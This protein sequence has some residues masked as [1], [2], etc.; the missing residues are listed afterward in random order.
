MTFVFFVLLK[1]VFLWRDI[2]LLQLLDNLLLNK[3]LVVLYFL[4]SRLA[5]NIF[6]FCLTGFYY[7][8][9]VVYFHLN[10]LFY[11]LLLLFNI[12]MLVFYNVAFVSFLFVFCL[13]RHL[14]NIL[15][16]LLRFILSLFIFSY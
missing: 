14:E 8:W 13:L 5:H 16:W 4:L 9:D 15:I 10:F 11:V 6:L 2:M 3:S 1:I 7:L 12:S